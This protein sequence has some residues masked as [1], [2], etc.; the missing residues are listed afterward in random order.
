LNNFEHMI[1]EPFKEVWE[2]GLKTG[3]YN[4]KLCGAG[5]GGFLLGFTK[6][7][8]ATKKELNERNFE[9]IPVYKSGSIKR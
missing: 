3:N 5:G 7:F 8:D 9:I 1:L 2:S 6:N 4:L